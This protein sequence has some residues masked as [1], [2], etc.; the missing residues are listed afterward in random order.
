MQK[1]QSSKGCKHQLTSNL[2]FYLLLSSLTR[3]V[4]MCLQVKAAAQKTKE[5]SKSLSV[6][7]PAVEFARKAEKNVKKVSN[8]TAP[9]VNK[10]K[11][12]THPPPLL[13]SAHTPRALCLAASMCTCTHS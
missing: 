11:V 8:N 1:C 5:A 9:T 10:A 13:L 12:R 3:A 6:T 2:Q 7:N 4:P